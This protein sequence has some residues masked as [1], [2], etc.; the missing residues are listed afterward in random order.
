MTLLRSLKFITRHPLNRDH[1]L[2]SLARFAKW[3]LTSRLASGPVIHDWIAGSRFLV[4]NGETG[5]TGNIYTGLQEF[6]DMAFLLHVLRKDDLFVDVGANVGSYSILAGAVAGARGVAFEPV[7]AIY[8][9][10]T[11]NVRLNDL[12]ERVTC[13]NLG[14]GSEPGE[15]AFSG[16][17]DTLDHVLTAEETSE[18]SLTVEISTLDTVLAGQA[19]TVMKIDVEGYETAVLDGASATLQNPALRAV[20]LELNGEG[21]R[22]GFDDSRIMDRMQDLGFQTYSYDPMTRALSGVDGQDQS[23]D[24]TLFVRDEPFVTDRLKSSPAY[25]ILGKQL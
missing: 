2:A 14:L 13:L 6:Q 10:L 3:Q 15:V 22:Y 19:P 12:E 23:S 9:R 17:D 7:P 21:R 11:L 24:N 18:D 4:R 16:Q 1:K 20:I 5:L 25:E 8:Q